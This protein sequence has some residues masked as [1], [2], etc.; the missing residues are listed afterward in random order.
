VADDAE[1]SV[2]A[3]ARK[4]EDESRVVIVVCNF[5]PVPREGYRIGVPIGG[6]YREVLNTDAEMYGG[7]NV[8]NGG[9]VQSEPSESHGHPCS[10]ALTLPPLGTLI[11]ER[12]A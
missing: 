7:G 2:I 11:L 10:L 4:G 5:T 8:G 12:V 1:N 6:F 9:G 3:W